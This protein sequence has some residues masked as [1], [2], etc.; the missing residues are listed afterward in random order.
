MK[1]FNKA[2]E[3]FDELKDFA[4]KHNVCV[5]TATQPQRPAPSWPAERVKLPREWFDV[6]IVDHFP[7]ISH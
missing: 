1:D 3:T 2:Q 5:V 6:I 7:L 4:R